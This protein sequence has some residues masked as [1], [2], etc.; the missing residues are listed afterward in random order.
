[1]IVAAMDTSTAATVAG[2]M[3]DDGA[4]FEAR[5]DPAPGSRPNHA[6]R[7]LSLLEEALAAAGVGWEQV[8]RLAVGVGP[9]GF[10]GLRIGIAT[11]RG[12][13][14]TH[15]MDVVP[16]SSLA[17]LARVLPPTGPAAQVPAAIAAAID[18]RR[19]EVFGAAWDDAMPVVPPAAYAPEDFARRVSGLRVVGTGAL[20]HRAVFEAQGCHVAPDAS[21]A[22]R[23]EAAWVCRLGRVSAPVARD[24]LV[25]DYRREPDAVPPSLQ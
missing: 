20:V 19:G 23:I 9:G 15:G 21:P 4:V 11:A 14:Q 18:A 25:P 12:L 16:V 1:V 2:V 6:S 22:H 10:T 7:L 13:A 3:R 8:S 17:A 24:A 5:D